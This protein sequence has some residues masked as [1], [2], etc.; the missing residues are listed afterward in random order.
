MPNLSGLSNV[1]TA[2]QALSNLILVTPA[3]TVG[4]QP[5]NP[6]NPDGTP[7][8]AQQPPSF[9]FDYEGEQTATLD[10]DITD[11]YV[12]DNTAIQDQIAL[13]PV[14]VTTHGFVGELNDV[15]P[16][17]LKPVKAIADKLTVISAYEP[18]IS[19]TALIA[20]NNAFQLYQVGKNAVD[21]AVSAWSSV[22]T[23]Q[24]TSV[25]SGNANFPIAVEPNQTKQQVAFQLF[26][27]YWQSRTLFTLQTPWAIFQNMAIKTLRAIQDAETRVVTDFEVSFKQIRTAQTAL[28]PPQSSVSQGRLS[29]QSSAL[30]NQGVSTPPS[31][32]SLSSGLARSFPGVA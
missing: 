16:D 10:S 7:S 23:G 15:V 17:F 11:H 2:A 3:Q 19:E 24:G 12:E 1:T 32:I 21:A 26:Y 5:Q 31:S 14:L 4:Y 25:I 6:A 22:T 27:G 13:K 30:T 20:Y 28:I 29:S 18:Q 9:V 8:T